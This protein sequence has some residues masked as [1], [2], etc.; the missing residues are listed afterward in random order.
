[1]TSGGFMDALEIT[2]N[3]GHGGSGSV[4][5]A[6]FKFQPKAGPDGGDGGK[7]GDIFL[8]GDK[9]CEGLEHLATKRA[10]KADRG[11]NGTGAK[12]HGLDAAPLE[13]SVPLG[14]LAHD[15]ATRFRLAEITKSGQRHII[16]RGGRG[17]RGN[18]HFA[19]PKNKIPRKFEEGQAG[20]ERLLALTYRVFA[21]TALIEDPSADMQLLQGLMGKRSSSPH[22]FHQRPR[23][24]Q[25]MF[26]FHKVHIAFLPVTQREELRFQFIE[27]VYFAERLLVNTLWMDTQQV[28]EAYPQLMRQLTPVAAPHLKGIWL[29]CRQDP[30]LPYLVELGERSIA[31]RPV[32]PP[33]DMASPEALWEWAQDGLREF[34]LPTAVV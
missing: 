20:E 6:R 19:T 18:V 9:D 34:F 17:G 25:G 14:T 8:V 27:H 13:I 2:V 15:V 21:P 11:G 24:V 32:I 5:F 4:H 28:D 10:L 16:V 29:L 22:R 26:D 1:M 30:G 3:A 12:K 33:A 7:G 23:R 31:V